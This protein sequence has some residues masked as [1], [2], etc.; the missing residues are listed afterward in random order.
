MSKS[1]TLY[2]GLWDN[3]DA[4]SE[5]RLKELQ[6]V[7]DTV[8]KHGEVSVSFEYNG[9]TRHQHAAEVMANMLPKEYKTEIGYNYHFR[10]WK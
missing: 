5:G 2:M 7:I 3:Y 10:I 6:E 1:K 8:E 9:R 4:D